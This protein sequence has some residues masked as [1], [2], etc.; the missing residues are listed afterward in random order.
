ML[1]RT[2]A[3]SGDL[4]TVPVN[5]SDER[6]TTAARTA[7]ITQTIG[8]PF[9]TTTAWIFPPYDTAGS[10]AMIRTEVVLSPSLHPVCGLKTTA[11]HEMSTPPRPLR[12]RVPPAP[13]LRPR[14]HV[15]TR[16][17][18]S[19]RGSMDSCY[20]M[21]ALLFW[22]QSTWNSSEIFSPRNERVKQGTSH[23]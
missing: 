12:P 2:A 9:L 8:H 1:W 15:R 18:D 10:H 5:V 17:H 13:S 23:V 6:L 21:G 16:Q 20:D 14:Q 3:L 22:R 7:S 11:M 4:Y 19:S